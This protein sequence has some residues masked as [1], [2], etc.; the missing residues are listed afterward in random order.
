MSGGRRAVFL[1]RDGVLNEL[2]RDDHSGQPESPLQV[3]DVLLIEG[4]AVAVRALMSRG[5]MLVCVTNQP[6]AAKGRV[7][8]STLEAVQRR[9]AEL[10]GAEGSV[11]RLLAHVP[12]PPGWCRAG[13]VG[14]VRLPQAGSRDAA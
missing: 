7:S 12:A 5:Y 1:D 2:V 10:L 3:A 4:A 9:V 8:V 13:A 6:A 14:T 11:A